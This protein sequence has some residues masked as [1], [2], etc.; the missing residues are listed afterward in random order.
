MR[1]L[2]GA[3]ERIGESKV[4]GIQDFC[5]PTRFVSL[6]LAGGDFGSGWR[7]LRENHHVFAGWRYSM[8]NE[9]QDQVRVV[10]SR[11]TRSSE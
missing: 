4:V 11:N 1:N 9:I 2:I 7:W 3:V 5:V 6:D 8:S 10:E